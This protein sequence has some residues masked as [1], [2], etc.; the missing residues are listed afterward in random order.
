MLKRNRSLEVLKYWPSV[1]DVAGAWRVLA[2]TLEEP[3]D[4]QLPEDEEAIWNALDEIDER[5]DRRALDNQAYF[6]VIA[7]HLI[8]KLISNY[9]PLT[10]DQEQYVRTIVGWFLDVFRQPTA[11]SNIIPSLKGKT[12]LSW[13]SWIVAVWK[14]I[15]KK[16]KKKGLAKFLEHDHQLVSITCRI[17]Q[18]EYRLFQT[19]R[20]LCAYLNP[21]A[22]ALRL[23]FT[24]PVFAGVLVGWLIAIQD[25]S[26]FSF[27]LSP[28]V[29]G[30]EWLYLPK[31][32]LLI[33]T[34]LTFSLAYIYHTVAGSRVMWISSLRSLG[35]LFSS[36]LFSGIVGYIIVHTGGERWINLVVDKQITGFLCM[37]QIQWWIVALWSPIALFVGI[38]TQLIWTGRGATEPV[39]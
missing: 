31:W 19:F 1:D 29:S 21:I 6:Y 24:T 38:V 37:A 39:A 36:L 3:P 32:L 16:K 10:E 17:L 26:I 33:L 9:K 7:A 8:R 27:L 34:P 23:L 15:G 11:G 28:V 12:K 22:A 14:L 4:L 5:G 30:D 2:K 35:V 18:R 25:T 20:V 13:Q